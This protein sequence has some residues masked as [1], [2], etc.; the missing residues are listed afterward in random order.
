[1]TLIR[2]LK[3]IERQHPSQAKAIANEIRRR[4]RLSEC[5]YWP[6]AGTEALQKVFDGTA[7]IQDVVQ[8]VRSARKK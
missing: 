2:R 1:M 8:A 3:R 6:A 5:D 4:C 7:T